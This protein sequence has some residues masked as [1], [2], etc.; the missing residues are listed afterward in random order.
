M[1]YSHNAGVYFT[2]FRGNRFNVV[3]L[4]GGYVFHLADII[5]DL[6]ANV[7]GTANGLLKAVH[8]DVSVP[9]YVTGCRVLGN[10]NKFLSAPLWRVTEDNGHILDMSDVYVKIDNMLKEI[11]QEDWHL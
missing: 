5:F 4:F 11:T 1:E 6:F 2:P 3:F 8:A 10:I 7:H 9:V